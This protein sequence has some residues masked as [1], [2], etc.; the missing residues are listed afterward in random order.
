MTP[1]GRINR[2]ISRLEDSLLIGLVTALLLLAVAQI[3]LR[4]ALGEGILWA[5][6]HAI[7]VLWIAMIG[8]MVACR[9]AGTSKLSSILRRVGRD[10]Y[11]ASHTWALAHLRGTRLRQLAVCRLRAH[12]W[13][14]HVFEPARLVVQSNCRWVHRDGATL[15][16]TP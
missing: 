16:K 9:E 8:G 7:A 11:S 10:A 3:V 5:S 12:G 4:N 6:P 2:L 14:D 15:L 13:H 1:L